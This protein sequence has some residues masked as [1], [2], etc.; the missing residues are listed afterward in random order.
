MACEKKICAKWRTLTALIKLKVPFPYWIGT[1]SIIIRALHLR[2]HQGDDGFV[3]ILGMLS[4]GER[5]RKM[6]KKV[7]GWRRREK[8]L[9]ALNNPDGR[10]GKFRKFLYVYRA[11]MAT[12]KP[13]NSAENAELLTNYTAMLSSRPQAPLPPQRH[14]LLA[15]RDF[16]FLRL[17]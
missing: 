3:P 14:V 11:V 4:C 6:R 15:F 17:K 5:Q 8:L 1:Y 9:F 7:P 16:S 12:L 2:E 13:K 10:D